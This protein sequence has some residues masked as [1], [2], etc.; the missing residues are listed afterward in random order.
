[1]AVYQVDADELDDAPRVVACSSCLHEWYASED[2]LLWGDNVALKALVEA[3]NKG[4]PS[5]ARQRRVSDR[6]SSNITNSSNNGAPS[7]LDQA[8]ITKKGSAIN[9]QDDIQNEKEE[10]KD[11]DL[12]ARGNNVVDNQLDDENKIVPNT[13]RKT[14]KSNLILSLIHI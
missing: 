11:N 10:D 5:Y 3:R 1:M 14:E 4:P 2:A 13:G 7:S 6:R 9:R 8:S 12:A